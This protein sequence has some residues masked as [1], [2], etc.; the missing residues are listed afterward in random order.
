M[1]YNEK[2][3]TADFSKWLRTEG[4]DDPRFNV[5]MAI[6]FKVCKKKFLNIKSDFEPQQ[7]IMLE[8]AKNGCV[9]KKLSDM[10]LTVKPF[11]SIQICNAKAYVAV[12][13][14]APRKKKTLYFIDVDK[15][16]D[17][18]KI[19]ENKAIEICEIIIIFS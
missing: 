13:W 14:P 5:S 3:L 1:K 7:I 17:I 10:D 15:L 8:Q 2:N 12:M 6:E 18:K 4:R 16:K 11:D 19:D 9:Y